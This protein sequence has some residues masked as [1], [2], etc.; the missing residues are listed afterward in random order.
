M[1]VAAG[2]RQLDQLVRRLAALIF[3]NEV[4]EPA[5]NATWR[6]HLRELAKL[7]DGNIREIACDRRRGASTCD[8]QQLRPAGAHLAGL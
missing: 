1:G 4:T 7:V 6:A 5:D 8:R 3:P 2:S